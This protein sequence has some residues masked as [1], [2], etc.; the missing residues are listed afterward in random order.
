MQVAIHTCETC[1]TRLQI[2][3]RFVGRTVRCTNCGAEFVASMPSRTDAPS[4]RPEP[5]ITSCPGCQT[6]LKVGAS[7]LD[8]KI[9]C[10]RCEHVF[11]LPRQPSA[12]P[13]DRGADEVP[14]RAR[15]PSTPPTVTQG[16]ARQVPPGPVADGP[17][18]TSYSH[19]CTAC[20]AAMQVHA[21]YFGRTLRCTSCRTEFEALPPPAAT[22]QTVSGRLSVELDR[23]PVAPEEQGRRRRWF[24]A[25]VVLAVLFGGVLWWL[26]SDRRQ[27]FAGDLFTVS[28]AR[29]EIGVLTRGA[30]PAVTVA[31]DREMLQEVIAALEAGNEEDLE[32]L[33]SSPRCIEVAAGTRV[34]VLERRKRAVEARVRVLEGPWESRIVWVPIDWVR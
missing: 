5:V 27:G 12:P 14:S 8:Q 18:A 15:T 2:L 26:G 32:R 25:A 3:E 34:R 6:R 24:A 33:R 28:K 16:T 29:T 19:V 10:P 1:G 7:H 22:P 11:V 4:D 9:R 13:Q 17:T 30:E 23:E 20:G 31:L 21:R